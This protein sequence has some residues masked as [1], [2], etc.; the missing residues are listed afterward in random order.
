MLSNRGMTKAGLL[1]LFV[2]II[3]A[4]IIYGLIA[5]GKG[6]SFSSKSS[7]KNSGNYETQLAEATEKYVKDYYSNLQSGEILTVKLSTL[8]SL[9]YLKLSNCRGYAI[10]NKDKKLEIEAYL[11]CNDFKSK[12]Y[13][14]TNE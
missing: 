13:D 10:V 9:N 1:F 3:I 4:C 14:E 2:I 7:K 8:E 11:N 6:F 12:N 5:F